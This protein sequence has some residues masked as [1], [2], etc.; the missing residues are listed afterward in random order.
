MKKNS[1]YTGSAQNRIFTIPNI[2]SFFRLCLIPV[3]VWQY[4]IAE[5]FE[6]TGYILLLSG[7][8]DIVDGYIARHFHM[9]SDLGKVLDPI[10]DKLTQGTVLF[11]LLTRF[12][13][14][15]VPLVLMLMKELYMGVS[16][17]LVIQR[18]GHV[19][20]ANWHGKVA[21]CLLYA[22]M[23]LHVVWHDIPALVSNITI[24]VCVLMMALSLL[25]YG[26][27]NTRALKGS[28]LNEER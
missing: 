23:I 26:V 5:N 22:M 8:T 15:I 21:T 10:A 1:G 19:L 25:L 18:T 27:R 6:L 11:C 17:F 24:A 12:H 9:T 2:L 13:L 3:I 14:M 7:L 4:C 28:N 16:G 20:G